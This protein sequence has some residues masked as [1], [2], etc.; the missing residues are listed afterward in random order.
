MMI[1][2]SWTRS[3]AAK[4]RATSLKANCLLNTHGNDLRWNSDSNV[5]WVVNVTCKTCDC[6]QSC[7][8]HD[9]EIADRQKRVPQK[10]HGQNM[11]KKKK[12]GKPLD[13]LRNLW[14]N[15]QHIGSKMIYGLSKTKYFKM[16]QGHANE[17]AARSV[18]RSD[19]PTILRNRTIIME[20]WLLLYSLSQAFQLFCRLDSPS[21]RQMLKLACTGSK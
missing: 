19:Q 5:C 4:T 8:H 17:N 10:I 21:L 11:L 12:K 15:E 6:E 18:K 20:G 13:C 14:F 3:V 7:P 1:I 9:K 16:W 2:F